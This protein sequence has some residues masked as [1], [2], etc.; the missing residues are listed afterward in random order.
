MD[1]A[2][3]AALIDHTLLRPE[4]RAAEIDQLSDDAAEL[5]TASACV[6]PR[7]VARV[8]HRLEGS[9]VRTCSVVSFPFG[10]QDVGVAVAET[11]R[12]VADGATEI[13]VVA[14]LAALAD[15]DFD[16]VGDE[17]AAVRAAAPAPVVL[18]V[19]LETGLWSAD[20]VLDGGAAAVRAGADFLKTSTGFSPSGGASLDTVRLLARAANGRGVKASGGIRSLDAALAMLD[21]GA[22]RLGCSATRD[23]LAGLPD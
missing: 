5:G 12:A 18:K 16:R 10:I 19:I 8:A 13:D 21:A 23:I 6:N 9:A 4:A 3:L 1:R 15:G 2:S 20:T 11:G 7:W 17:V 22:T 14:P